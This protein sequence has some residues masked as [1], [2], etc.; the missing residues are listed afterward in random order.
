MKNEAISQEHIAE[1]KLIAKHL[2]VAIFGLTKNPY[3]AVVLL[4]MIHLMLW[5]E[6]RSP[7]ADTKMMLEDYSKNF[8]ENFE[9][10]E[11]YEK[12]QMQ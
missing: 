7:N 9:M 5:M 10:N 6:I 2:C 3:E 8:L 12:G 4:T 11:A 1:L